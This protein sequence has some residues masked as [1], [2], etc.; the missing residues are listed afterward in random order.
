[1][2]S[3]LE[4]KGILAAKCSGHFASRI[5]AFIVV[6]P[7][8]PLQDRALLA[9]ERAGATADAFLRAYAADAA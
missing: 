8:R 5:P 6:W 7:H 1:M 2:R 4:Y 9:G 3:Q